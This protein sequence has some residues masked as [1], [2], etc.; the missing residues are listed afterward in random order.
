M[1]SPP[2]FR[3]S[4]SEVLWEIVR[5]HPLA[6]LLSTHDGEMDCTHL[7]M[8]LDT[9]TQTLRAHMARANEHWQ[10]LDGE[11]ALAIL[12]GPEHYISPSWYPSKAEHGKVVP[13]WNYVAVHVRGR[14]TVHE[15]TDFLLKNVTELTDHNER[16]LGTD[17]K[18]SDAPEEFIRGQA[19]AIVGIEMAIRSIEGKFK[20]S[21]NRA[22]Q[23]RAA[24]VGQLESLATPTSLEMARLMKG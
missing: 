8:F 10:R 9:S 21:Q 13:T 2:L 19:R 12:H 5:E 6:T 17:W 14:I 1:Y 24:V 11:S 3:E 22:P 15:D 18:V 7:P 4:R 23:D 20:L 16:R